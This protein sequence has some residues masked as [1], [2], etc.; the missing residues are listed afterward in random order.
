MIHGSVNARREAT[1]RLLVR[2]PHGQEQDVD[3][4]ID[5]GF[6]GQLTLPTALVV[7]LGLVGR[8]HGRAILADGSSVLYD[9]HEAS[10][11]WDGQPRR[12]MAEPAAAE[13]LVGM[14]PLDGYELRIQAIAGG[15]VTIEALP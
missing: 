12:V 6:T 13:A 3:A 8:G 7:G 5:T 11:L 4:V 10:L 1:I 2:G 15:S 14:E 9:V